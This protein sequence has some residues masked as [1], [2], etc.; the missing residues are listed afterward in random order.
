[1]SFRRSH[2][3]ERD[4]QAAAGIEKSPRG[5]RRSSDVSGGSSAASAPSSS[6]GGAKQ[7]TTLDVPGGSERPKERKPSWLSSLK[8]PKRFSF[9]GGSSSGG[10]GGSK[11][12]GGREVSLYSTNFVMSLR[13]LLHKQIIVVN[14]NLRQQARQNFCK[15]ELS[16]KTFPCFGEILGKECWLE[17]SPSTVI[18]NTK[19]FKLVLAVTPRW[20]E[21]SPTL[22]CV[23]FGA[24]IKIVLDLHPCGT[25]PMHGVK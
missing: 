7:R 1:M 8:R 12:D 15:L 16:A 21:I 25:D 2:H 24:K 5:K 22:L 23:I 9:R 14:S 6:A 4:L 11:S 17:L 18:T 10:S 20:G 13:F 19:S 3:S